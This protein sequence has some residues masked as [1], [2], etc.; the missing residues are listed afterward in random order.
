ML[1]V[2]LPKVSHPTTEEMKRPHAIDIREQ[3]L[4]FVLASGQNTVCWDE[5]GL[6]WDSTDLISDSPQ[7]SSQVAVFGVKGKLSTP[8]HELRPFLLKHCFDFGPEKGYFMDA[9]VGPGPNDSTHSKAQFWPEQASEGRGLEDF[10]QAVEQLT[11]Q[12]HTSGGSETMRAF[13]TPKMVNE[14]R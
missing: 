8:Q 3:A 7:Q 10:Q 5:C 9:A 6:I 14:I 2:A 1:R 4:K 13:M 11:E 12:V